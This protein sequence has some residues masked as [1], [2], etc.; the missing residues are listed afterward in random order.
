MYPAT[1]S[2]E[3]CHSLKKCGCKQLSAVDFQH[4]ICNAVRVTCE[5]MRDV[6][7]RPV[8]SDEEMLTGAPR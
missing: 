2:L 8:R 1:Q 7:W 5:D 3:I 6:S 4:D